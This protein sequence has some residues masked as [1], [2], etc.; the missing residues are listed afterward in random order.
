MQGE[1]EMLNLIRRSTGTSSGQR[2]YDQ[3]MDGRNDLDELAEYLAWIL[4]DLDHM[5]VQ[6]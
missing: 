4:C 3:I 5:G 2:V 1:A 6:Y